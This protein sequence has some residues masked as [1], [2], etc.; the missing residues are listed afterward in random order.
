MRHS[1][2]SVAALATVLPILGASCHHQTVGAVPAPAPATEGY[3]W[4]SVFRTTLPA[5]TVAVRFGRAFTALGL[6]GATWAQRADTTWA[7]A[8]PTRL[9]GAW[10]GGTYAARMVA[11]RNGD[12]THF[13]HFVAVTPPPQGWAAPR[14]SVTADGRHL[15]L[16]PAG[17]P[18]GFCGALGRAARVHGTAPREPSGEESLD[19][20]RR[21]P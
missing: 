7:H 2:W 21:R 6:S 10:G 19:V 3:C 15:S 4:W 18:I 14:D 9:D 11:Y 13:R 16:S 1:S 20:W 17:N 8:G 12:S 5:D